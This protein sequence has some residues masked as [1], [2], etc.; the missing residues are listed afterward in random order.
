MGKSENESMET[1]VMSHSRSLVVWAE[2]GKRLWVILFPVKTV[3]FCISLM[4]W[5]SRERANEKG[6]FVAKHMPQELAEC[7]E[8]LS[9]SAS[10][11]VAIMLCCRPKEIKQQR[12]CSSWS[13]WE[14]FQVVSKSVNVQWG[15]SQ[16]IPSQFTQ[17][18]QQGPESPAGQGY[19]L[20]WRV[21]KM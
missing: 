15:L 7:V 16:P 1:R 8:L 2:T 11:P 9:Y 12:S 18:F 5:S 20:R 14:A 17:H 4:D 21:L 13:G 19:K 3:L 6:H 10:L